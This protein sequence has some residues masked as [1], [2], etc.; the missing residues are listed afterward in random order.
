MRSI[1][2]AEVRAMAEG[3]AK[4]I[5]DD[6]MYVDSFK[7]YPVPRGGIYAALLLLECY[8]DEIEIVENP[9]EA[10][11][12]IDDI[13]DTGYTKNS[14]KQLCPGV[15]FFALTVRLD[16]WIEFPW[17]RAVGDVPETKQGTVVPQ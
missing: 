16:E 6:I 1:T 15:P 2:W 13:I 8:A 10:D 14:Y 17:E 5:E 3:V 4:A 7:V 12:I 9:E 11:L